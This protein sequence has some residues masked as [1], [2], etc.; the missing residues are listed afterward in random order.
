MITVFT[1][2]YNRGH[3]LHRIF[4]SLSA[5]TSTN[6]EWIIVDDG[7]LDDTRA[8]VSAI[9]ELPVERTWN[10]KYIYKNNGGKHTAINAG[11]REAEGEL[12]FILDSDDSLPCDAIKKIELYYQEKRHLENFGG[13]CGLIAHHNGTL[14]GNQ[15]PQK[16]MFENEISIRYKYHVISDL[17]EVFRTNVLREFPFPETENEKFCPEALIWNRIA[18]KYKL[19]CFNEV[20]YFR[21]YLDGGLTDRIISIRM[22]SPI[23][24][25][26][27]YKEQA[28]LNIPIIQKIKA[29]INFW[30]FTL[31]LS[32]K[33]I[34]Y[35]IPLWSLLLKP[36]GRIMHDWDKLRTKQ[37]K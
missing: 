33:H 35:D 20:I 16:E 15:F 22:N 31:C 28:M 19:Y 32:N 23:H 21:D 27:T 37:N 34:I 3:L 8:V 7:S 9:M 12:F 30:R 2:T 17:A 25:T 13:V 26:M 4:N 14:I 6:F 1:P 29:W 5:Q 10:I 18:Q 24:T 11:V 36:F